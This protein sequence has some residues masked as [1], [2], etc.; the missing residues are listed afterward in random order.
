MFTAY[1]EMFNL[2]DAVVRC[3]ANKNTQLKEDTFFAVKLARQRLS[4]YCSVITPTL[5]MLLISVHIHNPFWKLPSFRKWGKGMDI[6]TEEETSNTKEYEDAIL[7]YAVKEYCAKLQHV[8][9]KT[10]ET[11]LSSNLVTSATASGSYQSSCDPY[12]LSRGDE[13]YLTPNEVA[14]AT[15]G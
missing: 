10:L 11:L 12:G 15:P 14:K 1:N 7:K 9:V 4:K 3:V 8:F 13:E 6:D 5:G 2:V